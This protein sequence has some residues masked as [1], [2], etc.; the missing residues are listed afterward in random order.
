M[1]NALFVVIAL[2]SGCAGSDQAPADGGLTVSRG[3]PGPQG[4]A[5]A[6]GP[7]GPQGIQGAQGPQG[8]QG[9]KG[10]I[11]PQGPMGAMGPQGLQGPQGQQ[12]PQGVDG[13]RGPAGPQ[14]QQGVAGPTGPQ[15]PAG[16]TGP[17]G[18][19]GAMGTTLKV[20]AA[21]NTAMGIPIALTLLTTNNGVAPVMTSQMGVFTYKNG[22][23]NVPDG[24]IIT[25]MPSAVYFTGANCTGQ[26]FVNY[27]PPPVR[28]YVF[29]TQNGYTVSPA[30][31]Q[32]GGNQTIVS[33]MS[34]S[35]ACMAPDTKV[36]FGMALVQPE[37]FTL[38]V[39]NTQPW[40]VQAQ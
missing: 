22:L 6:T 7:Q 8:P 10:D 36:S 40:L 9:M 24:L 31:N 17:Q 11:G 37:G 1:R 21:D 39:Q 30:P 2:L 29:W 38:V 19:A 20:Y 34:I 27:A 23:Q 5:G 33:M 18:T 32:P 28:N 26:E 13:A 15:G 12:G 35:G 14:G 4:P 16:A 25:P 3:E